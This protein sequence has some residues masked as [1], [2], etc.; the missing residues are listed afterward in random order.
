MISLDRKIAPII[1]PD[2]RPSPWYF[3]YTINASKGLSPYAHLIQRYSRYK[4]GDRT[5]IANFSTELSWLIQDSHPTINSQEWVVF[6]P[7]FST[8]PPAAHPLG[9][10]IAA[11]FGLI[12]VDFR[13]TAEGDRKTQYAAIST[14]QDR[15]RAKFAVPTRV[16]DPDLVRE[17][18]ALIIDDMITTGA[19]A[20]YL[21]QVL[22]TRHGALGAATFAMI[23]L[24]TPFPKME[25]DINRSLA[26]AQDTREL[27]EILNQG[28]PINRHIVKSL[29]GDDSPV[30]D[31]IRPRIE[32]PVLYAINQAAEQYYRIAK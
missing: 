29:Y 7:P 26:T 24:V 27:V 5:E 31:A 11:E 17:R 15:V 16:S 32:T 12:H 25:E 10:K 23:D 22:Q 14:L 9:E 28:N 18:K 8:L 2:E 13:T 19:T 6:T 1:A 3:T 21:E 20:S 30:F 4:Y